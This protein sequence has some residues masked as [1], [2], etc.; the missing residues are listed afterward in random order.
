MDDRPIVSS[1]TSTWELLLQP[2]RTVASSVNMT[3]SVQSLGS[4]RKPERQQQMIISIR[5]TFWDTIRS[6]PPQFAVGQDEIGTLS[7][8]RQTA[9]KM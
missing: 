9:P 8:H 2:A 1:D 3:I 7:L 4:H 5:N 6:G